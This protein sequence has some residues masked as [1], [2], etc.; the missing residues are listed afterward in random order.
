MW[1]R[2]KQPPA[3]T[4]VP[5][6]ALTSSTTEMAP[7]LAWHVGRRTI[8]DRAHT[9]SGDVRRRRTRRR[10]PPPRT[11]T[12]HRR[13]RR[14]AMRRSSRRPRTRRPRSTVAG[15]INGAASPWTRSAPRAPSVT[16]TPP[17]SQRRASSCA[18]SVTPRTSAAN[19][20][21]D[22][23]AASDWL[24]VTRRAARDG[25]RS[26]RMRIP[27]DLAA[28]PPLECGANVRM[29]RDPAAVVGHQHDIRFVERDGA[30]SSPAHRSH[31]SAAPRSRR[32]N[33]CSPQR[34]RTFSAVVPPLPRLTHVHSLVVEPSE[35]FDAGRVIGDGGDERH[36]SP[37]ARGER[38]GEAR[39]RPGVCVSRGA[40]RPGP[41][42]RGRGD[43]RRRRCRDRASA[44]PMTTNDVMR[45]TRRGRGSARQRRSP[46]T[47][48]GSRPGAP[49]GWSPC[50]S[51]RDGDHVVALARPAGW[52]RDRSAQG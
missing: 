2:S 16:T 15:T 49:P 35:Q 36:R 44:S 18:C 28:D 52:V 40:T 7:T 48:D 30:P 24:G 27:H 38:G 22:I 31:R 19:G 3:A 1:R 23:V 42:R 14:R 20:S 10:Q 39:H 32:S 6:A 33:V 45:R 9:A 29:G 13:G 50:A 51:A 37:G 21:P 4:T 11:A 41:G 17:A 25:W 43:R 12:P 5:P 26:A 8:V 47:A 34:M 46:R